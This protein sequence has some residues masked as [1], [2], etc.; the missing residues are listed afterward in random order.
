METPSGL[1]LWPNAQLVQAPTPTMQFSVYARPSGV[2][3]TVPIIGGG[4]PSANTTTIAINA[5]LH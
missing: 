1:P 4:E 2:A 5:P 3:A